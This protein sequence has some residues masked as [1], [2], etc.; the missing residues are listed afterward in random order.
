MPTIAV[1]GA[2]GAQG[3][4][5]VRQLLK[6]PEW[7]VRGITRN[8]HSP[9]AKKLAE[10]ARFHKM[11]ASEARFLMAPSTKGGTVG[12]CG[13]YSDECRDCGGGDFEGGRKGVWQDC[14]VCYGLCELGGG[15][16]RCMRGRREERR[17]MCQ[18]MMRRIQSR[19]GVWSGVC[20]AVEVE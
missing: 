7:K 10:Q 18:W 13:G 6:N 1:F 9:A 12:V 4:S 19:I 20:V 11:P 5:V 14:G 2:T 16:R 17:H 8:V 15:W 3:G